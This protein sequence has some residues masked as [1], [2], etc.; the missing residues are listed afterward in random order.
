MKYDEKARFIPTM[1]LF[2]I[3]SDIDGNPNRARSRIAAL[4]ILERRIW[5]RE[6]KYTPVLSSTAVRLLVSMAVND[7]QRLKQ[8]DCNNAF[9]NGILP[10]NC[11][12]LCIGIFLKLNKT[13]YELCRSAHHWYTKISNHLTDDM[14]FTA[15]GQN[16]CVY[17]CT[18]IEGQPPIYVGLY[19]DD[20]IYYSPSD[21]VKE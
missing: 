21:A 18:P 3:K 4:D 2:S 15:M 10:D 12:C 6:D 9:C 11:P 19:V 1:N 17:K 5:S 8:A 13:L 16:K 7:G 14:G 20:L